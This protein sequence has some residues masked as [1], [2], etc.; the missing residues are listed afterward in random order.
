MTAPPTRTGWRGPAD[1]RGRSKDFGGT[2]RRL[3]GR[4]TPH[5]GPMLAVAALAVGGIVLSAVGPRVLGH[6]TDLLFTGV[7][8]R[9]LP[10]GM[11]LDQ[12][13]AASDEP[14]MRERVYKKLNQKLR[15]FKG[16]MR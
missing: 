6:A 7:L 13:V 5:R 10:A 4:L 3:L 8:G 14:W 1:A 12:A 11:T 2:A 9:G 15:A 16:E